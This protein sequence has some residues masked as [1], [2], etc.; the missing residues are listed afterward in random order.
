ALSMG[1]WL[2]TN[3]FLEMAGKIGSNPNTAALEKLN[4]PAVEVGRADLSGSGNNMNVTMADVI[5]F[6]NSVGNAPKI[7]ATNN[8]S[9]SYTA[10]PAIGT[11]VDLTGGGLS[12]TFTPQVWNTTDNKWLST[13][14][15]TGGFNGSTVFRGAGAGT[16]APAAG[17]AGA[18]SGTAAGIAK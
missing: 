2:E 11:G 3:K 14:N 7:W 9:G 12:A 8:V 5:F 16:I 10:A 17:T 18:I 15:G 6:A 13:V 1:V 4:I